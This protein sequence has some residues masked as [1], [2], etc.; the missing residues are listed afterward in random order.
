MRMGQ[1]QTR[2]S[3][4]PAVM[5]HAVSL[6]EI[7]A[8]RALVQSLQK[9]RPGLQVIVSTTTE[10]GYERGRQLYGNMSGVTLIRFPLDFS[11]AVA[12]VLDKLRPS[13]VVLMELEVWPNFLRQC[14]RR[15]IPV[16]VIN[17]RLTPHSLKRYRWIAPITRRMFSRL[18]A[19][20]AQE[21]AYA[22]QFVS[23]GVPADRVTVTG[24]MKFDTA[25]VGKTVDGADDLALA[26]GLT[27]GELLWVCGSTGPGEEE[28]VLQAYQK[29]LKE[30]PALR[31]AIV[32]R[33][34]DRFD[35]VARLI[36]MKGYPLLRRSKGSN[37]QGNCVIL[38]DTMGEL[39][40]FYALAT[41]VLVGRTLVDL[42]SRQRGS[43]MIEPAA[44]GKPTVVGPWTQN[45]AEVMNAFREAQAIHEIPEPEALANA[46]A[47]ILRDPQPAD[48]LGRRAQETVT[49]LQGATARHV[50]M[51]LDRLPGT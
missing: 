47:S 32:P 3:A 16:M 42:G 31:L 15:D 33:H 46:I 11:A 17:A 38:G 41:V 23:L 43:D 45:F 14:A 21:R 5:I 40:K 34:P 1:V 27:R 13:V 20:G 8:T 2:D 28:I 37:E 44:L 49:R 25:E 9:G 12:R 10:T 35:E 18:A 24:T 26:L 39:R 29:L 22:E 19:V 4:V 50:E 36:E 51:I 6:G 7:N 48:E 30:F